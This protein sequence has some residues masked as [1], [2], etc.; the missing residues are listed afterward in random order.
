VVISSKQKIIRK[1]IIL[2]KKFQVNFFVMQSKEVWR[3]IKK[4]TDEHLTYIEVDALCE[5]AQ[6]VIANENKHIDGI[7]VESGCALGGSAIV[8]ASAK[9]KSRKFFIY[10]VFGMI[11]PPSERDEQDVHNRYMQ[12]ASGK[13]VGLGDKTYYGY[14]KNLYDKV[15]QNFKRFGF[16][17]RENN[18]CL[19]KGLYED[20][21]KI[22]SPV[23]LAHIDCDWFDSVWVC[24]QRIEPYLISGGTLIIDDYYD[25]SG[26]KKAVDEYFK[27]KKNDYSFIHKSR[28]HIVKK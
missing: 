7:I 5:L 1:L 2:I 24:L 12:I 3:V 6:V 4:V 14:E 27:N 16:E 21:L 19:V 20:T 18:V 25:W 23:A 8:I 26:C 9:N 15:T 22:E 17:L 11:P 28:L 10:D 13:S